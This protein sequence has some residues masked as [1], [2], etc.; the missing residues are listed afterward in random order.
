MSN[1]IDN[2]ENIFLNNDEVDLLKLLSF[3]W[4]KK[5]KIIIITSAFTILSIIYSFVATSWYTSTVT[6]L[7]SRGD[8]KL[9]QYSGI[10]SLVGINIPIQNENDQRLYPE[11]I[12]SNFV[13]DRVLMN[14]FRTQ[15][16]D[17]PISLF[18][19]CNIQFDSSNIEDKYIVHQEFKEILRKEYSRTE[20]DEK[21]SML[22]ISISAPED[23]LLASEL[24]N[25]FVAQLDYYN[26]YF[27]KHKATEQRRYIEKGLEDTNELLEI[28]RDNL[29]EFKESNKNIA[30]PQKQ[31]MYEKLET[32]MQV[33]KNLYIE[34]K[35]QLELAKIEEIK[36]TET[37]NILDKG[38][39]PIKKSKP[40]RLFIII[41]TFMLS[42]IFSILY[43]I[44]SEVWIKYK[45][46]IIK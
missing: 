24:A 12:K 16:S 14:K 30:S 46:Q 22:T 17:Q 33:Q 11:I 23:P 20:I 37:L 28:I 43:C 26:R 31:I 2:P 21:S 27:R 35:K 29:I 18:E 1:K 40:K 41:T 8:N 44:I 39:I 32:E 7:P 42:F 19:F 15:S 9:N 10:A 25:F 4:N 3:L 38:I 5:K 36:E 34:L 6:I 13:L 45:Y